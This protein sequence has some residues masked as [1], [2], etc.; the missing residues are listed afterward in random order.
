MTYVVEVIRPDQS[1]AGYLAIADVGF[2]RHPDVRRAYY[3]DKEDA[4][5]LAAD[6][7][8]FYQSKGYALEAVALRFV[9]AANK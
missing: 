9:I 3:T 6:F 8:D 5:A 2:K 4:D 7:N 1:S